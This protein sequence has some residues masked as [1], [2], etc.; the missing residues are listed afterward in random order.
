MTTADWSVTGFKQISNT[1]CIHRVYATLSYVSSRLFSTWQEALDHSA[2]IYAAQNACLVPFLMFLPCSLP[3][4][5]ILGVTVLIDHDIQAG[6]LAFPAL[7]L[8]PLSS[9]WPAVCG[10]SWRCCVWRRLWAAWLAWQAASPHPGAWHH[11]ITCQPR[12]ALR[13]LVLNPTA[14]AF[15]LQC[16]LFLQIWR[17]KEGT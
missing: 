5:C 1:F 6:L 13:F 11:G 14:A 15:S 3:P 2:V 4:L 16:Q 10:H 17:S 8:C 9:A 7:L 12:S